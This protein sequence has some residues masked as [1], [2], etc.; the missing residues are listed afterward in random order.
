MLMRRSTLALRE[1]LQ[2]RP[3]ETYERIARIYSQTRSLEGT[4]QYLRV[5]I[6]TLTRIVKQHPALQ[7]RL[8]TIRK[9]PRDTP[10]YESS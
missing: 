5:P 10:I 1:S 9:I 8:R 7:E 2:K 3:G 6:R 4:A